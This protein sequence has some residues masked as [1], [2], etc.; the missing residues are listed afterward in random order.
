MANLPVVLLQQATLLG[1]NRSTVITTVYLPG[2]AHVM[3][4]SLKNLVGYVWAFS[5]GAEY[6]SAQSGLGYLTY[7]TYLYS[8]MGKLAV[9]GIIYMIL[10]YSSFEIATRV[11]RKQMNVLAN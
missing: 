1:A 3:V 7:Q 10:G 2:I 4:G 8:D 9:F 5:L 11:S 6:I